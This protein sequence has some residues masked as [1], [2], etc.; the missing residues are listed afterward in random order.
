MAD[1][2]NV[3]A[4]DDLRRVRPTAQIIPLIS[5]EK[6]VTD[7]LNN[8]Q[9]QV[10]GGIDAILK[11]LTFPILNWRGRSRTKSTSTNSWTAARKAR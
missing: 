4:L 11:M 9:T 5:T 10:D 1:P 3:L 6:A 7:F 8:V 2:L